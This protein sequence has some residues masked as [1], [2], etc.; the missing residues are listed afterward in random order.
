[1]PF[2]RIEADSNKSKV[3]RFFDQSG[4]RIKGNEN[5]WDI[6]FMYPV[7]IGGER[8]KN[9]SKTLALYDSWLSQTML[10]RDC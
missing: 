2:S 6:K 7:F 10:N 9:N 8:L 4:I 3:L 1:M 5:S